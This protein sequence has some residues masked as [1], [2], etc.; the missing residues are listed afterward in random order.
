MIL[1]NINCSWWLSAAPF[2]GFNWSKSLLLGHSFNDSYGED[3]ETQ[4]WYNGSIFWQ[5]STWILW[6]NH[7]D[8]R[9][10]KCCFVNLQSCFIWCL[11]SGHMMLSFFF[12]SGCVAGRVRWFHSETGCRTHETCSGLFASLWRQATSPHGLTHNTPQTR[13]FL[14]KVDNINLMVKGH[15]CCS[16]RE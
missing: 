11:Y 7:K 2:P 15:I 12:F 4:T 5:E 3:V 16:Q 6:Q 1:W 9:C 10:S 14:K 8:A 13:T